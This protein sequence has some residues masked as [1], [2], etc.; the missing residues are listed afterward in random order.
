MT[1][2]IVYVTGREGFDEE[3]ATNLR[4][5]EINFLPGSFDAEGTYLVWVTEDALLADIK[6]TVGTRTIFKYRMRF[7]P[8][9]IDLQAARGKRKAKYEFT[10]EQESMFRE[11][12][13]LQN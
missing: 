13:D 5:S 3:L 7:F 8:T 1:W 6:K 9:V 2:K 11:L 12:N 10:A 4:G